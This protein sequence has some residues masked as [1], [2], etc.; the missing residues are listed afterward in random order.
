M[1]WSNQCEICLVIQ[2]WRQCW[3]IPFLWEVRDWWGIRGGKKGWGQQR[4]ASICI[5]WCV[6]IFKCKHVIGSCVPVESVSEVLVV[7]LWLAAKFVTSLKTLRNPAVSPAST[8][9]VNME[10]SHKKKEILNCSFLCQ[11]SFNA[12]GHKMLHF[13]FPSGEVS[14]N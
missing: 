4:M 7:K 11:S 6:Y 12:W 10:H 8:G 5:V 13:K 2:V 1:V 14:R 9:C 3:R